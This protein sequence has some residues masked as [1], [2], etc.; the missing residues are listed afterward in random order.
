[1]N[2]QQTAIE[3]EL[4]PYGMKAALVCLDDG[5]WREQAKA[6]FTAQGYYLM[7]EPDPARAAAKLKL[8]A[9]DVAVVGEAKTEA[10]E[11][12]HSRPGMRRRDT[13]LFVVGDK[14]SLDSWAA[15]AAGADWMLNLG[16]APRAAELLSEALKRQEASR[17]PWRLAQQQ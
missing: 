15:F 2:G 10:L 7:D 4:I 9:L 13:A 5:P 17:E 12:M 8:N 3:P 14:P 11:E 1:M 6:F 16:D